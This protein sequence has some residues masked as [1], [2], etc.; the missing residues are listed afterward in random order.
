MTANDLFVP[1][2]WDDQNPSKGAR[3]IAAII[4]TAYVVGLFVLLWVVR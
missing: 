3:L 2:D 4:A 1:P